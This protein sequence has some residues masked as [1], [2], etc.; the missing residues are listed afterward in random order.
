MRLLLVHA[1]RFA[2][3]AGAPAGDGPAATDEAPNEGRLADCVVA[4]VT[5][6]R[7]DIDD[8][9]SVVA[10]AAAELRDATERLNTRKAAL[11]PSAHLSGVPAAP[12][13]AEAVLR[14]LAAELDADREILRAPLSSHSA[15]ELARKGHPYAT[16][17][18]RVI[19]GSAD[20]GEETDRTP[21]EW[22]LAFPGGD[23]VTLPGDDP[24][25]ALDDEDADRVSDGLRNLVAREVGGGVDGGTSDETAAEAERP[26]FA[27]LVRDQRLASDGRPADDA[28]A[29]AESLRWLP[30]GKLVR[31]ALTA[32]AAELAA[33]VGAMPVETTPAESLGA[34]TPPAEA[35]SSDEHRPR[36]GLSDSVTS[37]RCAAC[38]E[39]SSL[40]EDA[41]LEAS[42]LPVGLSELAAGSPPVE[43]ERGSTDLSCSPK[44]VVPVVH[45]A[46]ADLAQAKERLVAQAED[47]LRAGEDLGPACAPVIRTTRAFSDDN[48]AWM[49][50]L[51]DELGAPAL[52][53]LR[54][55]RR[56]DREASVD[57][58]TLDGPGRPVELGRVELDVESAERFGV[59][60]GA[61][62]ETRY[63]PILHFSPFGSVEDALA[64]LLETA[65]EREVPR[66][67]TWLSPAQV[68]FVPVEES[69]VEHCDALAADLEAGGI[70]AEVDDREE[71]VGERLSRAADD[72]VPYCA[73]VGDRE[74][75]RDAETLKVTVR[76]EGA[77]R[78][79]TPA[80]LEEAVLADIDDGPRV[81]LSLPTRL[82][83]RPDLSD[84]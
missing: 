42:D 20:S 75:E 49:Q 28:P 7:A 65:A 48:E 17:S 4:F 1:D 34:R 72:W 79:L 81:A 41:E 54:P 23:A 9:D 47:A 50:S 45:T 44:S 33:D 13:D 27:D 70:R 25:G 55:E 31:D 21:S 32:Y 6:E 76:G 26:T 52:V 62:E 11:Y 37:T 57:F 67:P 43:G 3:E 63:P 38:A 82:G 5:V 77:E 61:G 2:F 12:D 10:N 39:H 29:K 74:T 68:R 73:V 64:A 19:P 14:D 40:L 15:F 71:A 8:P 51:V 22:R 36:G 60:Y 83:R 59:T 58:V 16:R 78:E 69:H 66:L 56:S 46:T 53:E 35:E 18:L 84:R 80:E 30:R 24:L